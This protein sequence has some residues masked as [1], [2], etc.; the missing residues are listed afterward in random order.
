[1][2]AEGPLAAERDGGLSSKAPRPLALPTTDWEQ[3]DSHLNLGTAMAISGAAV[4]PVAGVSSIPGGRFLLCLF[5]ARL[6]DESPEA[7]GYLLY[8]KLSL[9]GNEPPHVAYYQP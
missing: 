8:V 3:E 1:M 9:T 6:N 5:N 4:S 7:R 2:L